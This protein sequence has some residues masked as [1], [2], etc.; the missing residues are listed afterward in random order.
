MWKT[1]CFFIDEK[2]FFIVFYYGAGSLKNTNLA[3]LLKR[4]FKHF[5]GFCPL[6][7]LF[8]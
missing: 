5:Y 1:S 3:L 4:V 8:V 7:R 6:F 2:V